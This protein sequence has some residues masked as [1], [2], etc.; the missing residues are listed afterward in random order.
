MLHLTFVLRLVGLRLL[1]RKTRNRSVYLPS[2]SKPRHTRRRTAESCP[3]HVQAGDEEG[4]A[5]NF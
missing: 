5:P 2:F 3:A 4:S 1:Q